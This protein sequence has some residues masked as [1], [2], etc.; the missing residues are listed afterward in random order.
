MADQN[1]IVQDLDF[2]TQTITATRL[3]PEEKARLDAEERFN[4]E[5]PT[6]DD[7]ETGPLAELY[8]NK[9]NNTSI[10]YPRD[11]GNSDK[12]HVVQFSIR[13]VVPATIDKVFDS[14]TDTAR[15]TP[16][17]LE[18]GIKNIVSTGTEIVSS[19]NLKTALN[20]TSS[21]V[22]EIT[23]GR[24]TINPETTSDAVDTI[25]LYMP[26][27]LSFSYGAQYDR[28]SL[29]EAINSVPLV[30]KVST[31][32]TSVLE[33]RAT[34][35]VAN[36]LGYT[37]N[38]QQQMMFEGIDFR[39]FDLEFVFTP[40]SKEEALIVKNIIKKL[41]RAAAPTRNTSAGGFFFTPPSVFEI[42]FF[43]NGKFNTNI[44]PIRPCVLQ[45]INVN[46]APNGWAS[47]RDGA[48]VQTSISLNFREIELV[49]RKSIEIEK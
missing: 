42:S 41:R 46:Y 21:A 13:D 43:F 18:K 48:P 25:R 24:I 7:V 45:N 10:A 5:G 38:P 20:V 11:L 35:A 15:K 29:A 30:A 6:E 1:N 17:I 19:P 40:T 16:E 44:Q 37:F 3:T 8:R 4:Q 36:R 27:T 2:G 47:L 23:R 32:I 22:A 28:L 33:N 39:E 26:D 12:G 49:D 34:K 9:Y 14:V 31:A